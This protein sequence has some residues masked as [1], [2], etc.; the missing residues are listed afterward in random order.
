MPSLQ[1]CTSPSSLRQTDDDI[2][3]AFRTYGTDDLEVPE[4]YEDTLV[5]SLTTLATC[6]AVTC[7]VCC[8]AVAYVALSCISIAAASVALISYL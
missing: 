7:G 8:I 3:A 5:D 6:G 4:G 2:T 1:A